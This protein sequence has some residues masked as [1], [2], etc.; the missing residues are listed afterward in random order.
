MIW[1]SLRVIFK[2]F[3]RKS[4]WIAWGVAFGIAY[5]MYIEAKKTAAS[6][7]PTPQLSIDP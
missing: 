6:I 2:L 4:N 7:V 3:M 5:F 1:I